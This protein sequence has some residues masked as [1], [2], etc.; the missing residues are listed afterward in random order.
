[1]RYKVQKKLEDIIK[2][3]G[4][5]DVFVLA[6]ET[7]CDETSA[8]VVKNGR[9][10]LSNIISSQIDIHKRF[11]GVVPEVASRSHTEAI[12]GVVNEALNAAKIMLQQIDAVA[13]TYGAG[14]IGALM[15]GVSFAKALSYALG[16]PLI[17]VNHIKAHVAANYI[18]NPDLKPP[19][20]ALI[21]SGGHTAI[22]SVTSYTEQKLI[23]STVDDAIGEAYDKVAR[24][25]GLEYPGGP[26]VDKLAKNGKNSIR[27]VKS[28]TLKNSFDSSFSGL[29]TA[30]INY[31]NTKKQ[32]SE[33]LNV[34]DI[35][36]SFQTEAVEGLISKTIR[37]CLENNISTLV[38]AGGVAAN[39]YIRQRAFEECKKHN[40]TLCV[41]PL[42]YCTDN[43]AMV[44]VLGYYNL[45][46]GEGIADDD[47]SAVSNLPL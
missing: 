27:F 26:K 5:E 41:P 2:N 46:A 18:I 21:V 32:R 9:E 8:A 36:C 47:L 17:K 14:L 10:V 31:I 20:M 30:V 35:C 19:F 3:R 4:I 29:K 25:L 39:S 43:A 11:G 23:G 24:V 42:V 13:V 6:I 1:M 12:S 34:E 16:V 45:M 33:E 38:L 22:V 7:S 37:A 44:G 28:E 40:I 15:V